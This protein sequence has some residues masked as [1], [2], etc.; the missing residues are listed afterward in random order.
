MSHVGHLMPYMHLRQ[1]LLVATC[2][3]G[4]EARLA[5]LAAYAIS[6]RCC[7]ATGNED[8]QHSVSTPMHT[9][10]WMGCG[11]HR[12]LVLIASPAALSCVHACQSNS[13]QAAPTHGA[14]C[15]CIVL[16]AVSGDGVASSLWETRVP[17]LPLGAQTL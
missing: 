7:R 5:R 14:A 1:C 6:D 15:H 3:G 13:C 17:S 4:N 8:H 2:H 9:M 12:Q 11:H 16:H 10:Q